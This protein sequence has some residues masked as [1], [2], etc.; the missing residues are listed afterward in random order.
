[1]KKII[2]FFTIALSILIG[3]IALL[4]IYSRI[5]I[6]FNKSDFAYLMNY[7]SFQINENMSLEYN[8]NDRLILEKKENYNI[9]DTILFKYFDT[10]KIVEINDR[11]SRYY[12]AFDESNNDYLVS[13][14]QIVGKVVTNFSKSYDLYS[15]LATP[16]IV[17]LFI[18]LLISYIYFDNKDVKYSKD[19]Y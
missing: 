15:T 17:V 16:N 18:I 8:I 11:Y 6:K 13:S 9:G 3:V 12:D 1:M 2:K 19:E 5:Y 7:T 10:Y 4:E 14:N